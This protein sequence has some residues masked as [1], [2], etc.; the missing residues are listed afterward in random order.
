MPNYDDIVG[1]LPQ[2]TTPNQ[3]LYLASDVNPD[4]EASLRNLSK[5]TGMPVE[6]LRLKPVAQ[7]VKRSLT[8]NKYDNI[9]KTS[10]KL[11]QFLS[12][13]NNANISHDDVDNL[14]LLERTFRQ[15]TGGNIENVGMTSGGFGELFNI[16]QRKLINT[17]SD[18]LLPP[19]SDGQ[20]INPE[21][22]YGPM[23]GEGLKD[24]GKIV[25]DYA[26]NTVKVP[27][28]QQTFYDQVVGGIGQVTSQVIT[29]PLTLGT[30]L[31]AQGADAMAEKIATDNAPQDTKDNA[32]L[33]GSLVTGLTEKWALDKL[34][35]PLDTKVKSQLGQV[36]ARIGIAGGAEGVQEFSE[37]LLQDTIRQQMVNPNATIDV[38]QSVEEGQ[39]GATVGAVVRS[40]VEAGLHIKKRNDAALK[41]QAEQEQLNNINQLSQASRVLQRDQA[42]FEDYL[43]SVTDEQG[44][45]T[46]LY[47]DAQTLAQSGH[48]QKITEVMPSVAEQLPNALA[49][50]G[51]IRLDVAE[52]A[53][54]VGNQ[55]F[56]QSLVQDLKTDPDGFSANEAADF[57]KTKAAE[58]L[59]KEFEIANKN[60]Q[61]S[62]EFEQSKEKVR[63]AIF[64]GLSSTKRF[65]GDINE[66]YSNLMASYF[67]TRARNLGQTPEQVFNDYTVKIASKVSGGDV[68]GQS[69]PEFSTKE[70]AEA[71]A[72]ILQKQL[73]RQKAK[74]TPDNIKFKELEIKRISD[75]SKSLPSE[76]NLSVNTDIAYDETK[77]T[78]KAPSPK[79]GQSI[80]DF[81]QRI[82]SDGFSFDNLA[83]A[84]IDDV[85]NNPNKK[86]TIYRA[87]AVDGN[88]DIKNGDWVASTKQYA[89]NHGMSVFGEGKYKIIE[90]EVLPKNIFTDGNSIHEF[91]YVEDGDVLNKSKTTEQNQ[92][93][94]MLSQADKMIAEQGQLLA[95]NGKPSK[96][97]RVQ[98]AQVRTDNFKTWFGDWEND[99]ANASKV[100]DDNGEPLVV[101]HGTNAS[102][103]E[104]K[105][106]NVIHGLEYGDGFYFTT[107]KKQ[108]E[109]YGEKIKDIFLNIRN[110]FNP[111]GGNKKRAYFDNTE[112]AKLLF[113]QKM[114]EFEKEGKGYDRFKPIINK[115]DN[116]FSIDYSTAYDLEP[117]LFNDGYNR[118]NIFVAF[119]P[120]QI[121][122][123]TGNNGEFNPADPNILKQSSDV[124][125]GSF[126]P[127]RNI[128]TLLA[129]AN[130]STFLHE[131]MHFFL[132]TD[133]TIAAQI[134]SQNDI[135]DVSTMSKGE[136]QHLRDVSLL[137]K[138]VGLEGDIQQQITAWQTMDFEEKRTYHEKVAEMGEKYFFE[139]RAPSIELI[140][141]FNRFRN[142][143]VSVY[144]SIKK[145]LTAN[146]DAGK[147]NNEVRM[148]FDRMIATEEEI[149]L[150]E[151][152]R[153]MMPLVGTAEDL[154]M[155]EQ[156]FADYQEQA[157]QA[158]QDAITELQ[159][160]GLRDMKWLRNLQ[161]K[162]LKRLQKMAQAQ[163]AEVRRTVRAEVLS[164]SVYRAYSMLTARMTD[165]DK[166][167]VQPKVKPS[168][169]V[170][171]PT[172]DSLFVAIAKLGGI[173]FDDAVRE[174]GVDPKE[175]IKTPIFGKPVLRKKG[176][177]SID[178]IA[179]ALAED[180]YIEV[181]DSGQ[182]DTS[183]LEQRFNDE[184]FGTIQYSVLRDYSLKEQKAGDGI[185]LTGVNALRFD[186]D[187]L[188]NMDI[189]KEV[190]DILVARKMTSKTGGIHPDFVAEY[191]QADGWE[192]GSE[193]VNALA[194]S[195]T[196][197]EEIENRT[198]QRMTEQYAEL[199][200]EA[201]I[202]RAADIA[203][204]N[205]ARSRLIETEFKALAKALNERVPDGQDKN[206]RARTLAALPM[207]AK[208]L[209]NRVI[210]RVR[211]RDVRPSQ[212]AAA[213]TRAIRAFE[214]ART[215]EERI[216]EKKNQL[217]NFH[218]TREAYA[219][220]EEVKVALRYVKKFDSKNI[221]KRIEPDYMEQIEA[222]L[223]K[224]DFRQVSNKAVDKRKSLKKWIA[225]QEELGLSP[226]ID[227]RLI[228][229]ANK[230]HYKDLTV[231]EFRGVVEAIKQIEHMGRLK[232]KLLN[233]QKQ[234]NFEKVRTLLLEALASNSKNAEILNR[235]PSNSEERKRYGAK[236]FLLAH[237][238][239]STLAREFDGGKD[240]GIWWDVLIRPANDAA[241]METLLNHEASMKLTE[242]LKPIL[243]NSKW[244]KG[245][246]GKGKTYTM[247]DKQRTFN[248]AQRIVIALNMG[249]AGNTQRLLDGEGWTRADV[250]QILQDFNADE[251][252]AI[253]QVWDLFESYRPKVAEL[254]KRIYGKEPE[255]IEAVPLT[256][257]S[258]DGQELTLRGGYFPIKYDKE[259]S[260]RTEE[261]ANAETAK[262]AMQGAFSA[263]NVRRSFAKSRVAE[264]KGRPL[265]YDMAGMFSSLRELH[266]YLSWAEWVIDAKRVIGDDKVK[267]AIRSNYGGKVLRELKGWVDA[268]AKGD[269]SE[270][271]AVAR[272]FNKVRAN[273]SIAGLGFN[274]MTGALQLTGFLNG[275]VRNGYKYQAIGLSKLASNPLALAK[276]IRAKSKFMD[277]R[278]NTMFQELN[279]NMNKI[280]GDMGIQDTM[281]KHGFT[282]I[283]IMQQQV[284]VVTWQGAYEKAV[285]EGHGDD[286]AIAIADQVVR[287]TQGSGLWHDLSFVQRERN[288]KLFTVFYNYMGTVLNTIYTQAKTAPNKK[289]LIAD[290]LLLTVAVPAMTALLRN[291]LTPSDDDEGED[292]LW[293]VLR[294]ITGSALGLF[295]AFREIQALSNLFV[296]DPVDYSGT[297]GTKA[298]ADIMK[299]AEQAKQGE[300]D[301]G[302]TRAS[303]NLAGDLFG[304]PSAQIN[305]TIKGADAIEQ[306]KTDGAVEDAQALM[307]GYKQ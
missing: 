58:E 87:V 278:T 43:K 274:V 99:P 114:A 131:S 103:D 7:E 67:A 21:S 101:Y 9:I 17:L 68:L 282:L 255:W 60:A 195:N 35:G 86:A 13:P 92:F 30:G 246:E 115:E 272:F 276:E 141:V 10:P 307:F 189:G 291:G 59:Q 79:N 271:D 192:S 127:L 300:A 174:W 143:M 287:D 106:N 6:A 243:A 162:E 64:D 264:V 184:L 247:G 158:T 201:A 306:G 183:E 134:I 84:F 161:S 170:V 25:K 249:N 207:A 46:D 231:D 267:D 284:D 27:Q 179:R 111:F 19:T 1:Q 302:F 169:N 16:G 23:I 261:L 53:S 180:S 129:D 72:R 120:T 88:A 142:F 40:F 75:A 116:G 15:L 194:T 206:S 168:N 32:V 213:E 109:N 82:E 181:D 135:F 297:T 188:L 259:A 241:D 70:Q 117:S 298:F 138:Q 193:L 146:P 224:Y 187:S 262:Q 151:K 164:E 253:Q 80:L 36:L 155:T 100:V 125:L 230:T 232:T 105:K 152:A 159:T 235:E 273:V 177:R 147:I 128:I 49:T 96:L 63:Q 74:L 199:S 148:V 18:L 38:M 176:G 76:S 186:Y 293:K 102:F 173:N 118:G 91:G 266:H 26:R 61:Q 250:E 245:L 254:E 190:F 211:V 34:T 2:D 24:T 136:Q 277:A 215:I 166:L 228:D 290:M 226:D 191:L 237:L 110:P 89:E 239:G 196:P 5:Q 296:D 222:F 286:K 238:K 157:K 257:K 227:Q 288:L 132:E 289:K 28:N 248:H 202:Q 119:D 283:R 124:D 210:S 240:G 11:A 260:S 113:R 78:H 150:A 126:D 130:L 268:V 236:G 305:K 77:F 212:Y 234:R 303:I 47:I 33:L 98:W 292:W 185:D 252:Q 71:K 214:R 251:L 163:R 62:G 123:A 81:N 85:K 139:G 304:I 107:D 160:K 108:A 41:A 299:F 50:N 208:E 203:V 233:A 4:E 22:L 12:N 42:T 133:I 197:Q 20:K 301:D 69:S 52:Y 51:V 65:R 217:I 48:A 140:P 200:S 94:E 280:R 39:V 104:F 8:A 182:Y 165:E 270:N 265:S 122:S 216:T 204:H 90:K 220:Q 279:E 145:F 112:D 263:A 31:Y 175:N 149:A 153:S 57:V 66:A 178:D 219:A 209:A 275:A 37:N 97:N 244:F 45:V 221:S 14:G 95:P 223:E 73:D 229:D 171:D 44:A 144:K 256:V 137:L 295:V 281:I 172:T 294:E 285:A 258:K 198:D 29:T 156:E 242:I 218:L 121:K 55:E 205:E 225:A 154:G 56:A 3:N 93:T 54:R 83:Q 269:Q 167:P